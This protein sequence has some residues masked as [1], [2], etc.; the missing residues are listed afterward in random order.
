MLQGH[1]HIRTKKMKSLRKTRKMSQKTHYFRLAED[2]L[3]YF[4]MLFNI[5][6][7][8]KIEQLLLERISRNDPNILKIE[9]TTVSQSK[10]D[11]NVSYNYSYCTENSMS[12]IFIKIQSYLY[13]MI[14]DVKK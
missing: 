5:Y 1:V 14:I 2:E 12:M 6:D 7:K 9:F 13:Q 4:L 11:G 10:I 8:N 3:P